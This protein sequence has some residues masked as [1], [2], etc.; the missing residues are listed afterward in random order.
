MVYNRDSVLHK[1]KIH[2]HTWNHL[3]NLRVAKIGMMK[4]QK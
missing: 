4:K 1:L 3:K 2:D